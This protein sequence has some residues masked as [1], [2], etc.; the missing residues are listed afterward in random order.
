[1]TDLEQDILKILMELEEGVAAM[2]TAE[3]KPNLVPLFN[4]LS[5]ASTQ[6]PHDTHAQLVHYLS[7]GSYE[8]ARRWLKGR[9]AEN[10]RGIGGR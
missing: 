3:P 9:D 1:M 8:K 5:Q 2:K 6:L 4:R 10:Q 7:N